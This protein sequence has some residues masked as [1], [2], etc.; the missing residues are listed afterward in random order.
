MTTHGPSLLTGC[1]FV[2]QFR[3]P[4]QATRRRCGE[5][6]EQLVSGQATHFHSWEQ[7]MQFIE[8]VLT[9]DAQDQSQP[10]QPAP[11]LPSKEAHNRRT[12]GGKE[13]ELHSGPSRTIPRRKAF[14]A[15]D[16]T[17]Y[18]GGTRS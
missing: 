16:S 14:A 10:G 15:E 18:Q 5:R 3:S 1:A 6:V 8:Q 12:K 7:R 13:K 17:T 2:V 11:P 4:Q 9:G